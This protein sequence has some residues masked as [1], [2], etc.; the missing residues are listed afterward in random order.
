M[1]RAEVAAHPSGFV[2]ILGQE[3]FV[4]LQPDVFEGE[5]S[6]EMELE[7]CVGKV[8]HLASHYIVNVQKRLS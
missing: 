5:F 8:T 3:S 6:H 4:A 1:R 2:E 7:W